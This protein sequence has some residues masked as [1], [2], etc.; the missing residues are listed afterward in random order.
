[1]A[2]IIAKNVSGAEID[3]DFGLVIADAEVVILTD[4]YDIEEIIGSDELKTHVAN[5]DIVLNDGVS[6][7]SITD[8]ANHLMLQTKFI[9]QA[10][11][12]NIVAGY[13]AD[14]ATIQGQLT[15]HT[16]PLGSGVGGVNISFYRKGEVHNKWLRSAREITSDE[17]EF[18][19]PYSL[20]LKVLTYNNEED[21]NS[22]N[23]DIEIYKN[24]SLLFSHT[25]SGKKSEVVDTLSHSFVKLDK[26]SA[27][28]KNG[29]NC[30]NPIVNLFFQ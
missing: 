1:M 13:T 30:E 18:V 16:H 8:A 3:L 10:D 2:I 5:G 17:V 26:V 28:I 6:D 22:S 15:N 7:L 21:D 9:D 19:I 4:Y 24:S 27:K 12:D 23:C 25:I 20:T 29:N 11:E 14:L